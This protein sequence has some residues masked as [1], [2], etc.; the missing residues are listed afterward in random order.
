L[1]PSIVGTLPLGPVEL[2]GRVGV[3]FYDVEI[4]TDNG[5]LIDESGEDA[6]YGVGIGLTVLER[7]ALR[8]EYEQ[9]DIEEFDDADAVWLTAGWRF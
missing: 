7:L 1:T 3:M 9:V 6:V 8:L 5:P 2:F 4:N